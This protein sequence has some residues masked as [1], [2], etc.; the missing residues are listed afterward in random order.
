FHGHARFISPNVVDVGGT[1]LEATNVLI[2]TGAEPAKL[3]IAGEEHF[4]T[5][6]EFLALE[7]LPE[8]IV[9]VGGGYIAAELSH[10]AARAGAQVT[11]LQRG[12]RMLKHFE[13]DLVG[14][15]MEKFR[16]LG[17]DV[18]TQSTVKAVK[19]SGAAYHV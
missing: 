8:R 12:R 11:V 18:S 16:V 7:A 9:M 15:L 10:V 2:A 19:K 5:S 14:W 17:I 13:P 1:A 4:T 6:D 3:G